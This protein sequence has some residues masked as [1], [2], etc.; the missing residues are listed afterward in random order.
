MVMKNNK[1]KPIVYIDMDGTL[2]DFVSAFVGPETYFVHVFYARPSD[3]PGIFALMEPMPG[4][5]EAVEKLRHKYD[6]YILSSSPW[7]NPTALGDKLAW[8]KKYFGGDGSENIFFRKVVF[9]SVKHLSRGDILIDDRTANGAGDFEGE[10]VLF[11]SRDF[12]DWE[13]VLG[14]LI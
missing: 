11:G 5:I 14:Y 7:E 9:S 2:V 8:V 1:K 6:L 13:A 3:L 10:H 4:A 12:P